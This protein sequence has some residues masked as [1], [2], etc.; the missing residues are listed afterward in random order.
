MPQHSTSLFLLILYVQR[1]WE[2]T[3]SWQILPRL[4]WW[5]EKDVSICTLALKASTWEWH[6]PHLF[7]A[8][9]LKQVTDYI[10]LSGEEEVPG[11]RRT[12]MFVNIPDDSHSKSSL[13]SRWRITG[14]SILGDKRQ[15]S[16]SFK[17][18]RAQFWRI[19][20]LQLGY[21]ARV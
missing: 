21:R 14:L 12:R 8:E 5:R 16:L 3:L 10:K 18:M 7:T 20:G 9:W 19:W 2:E 17:S 13:V 11:R 6:M 1:G 4:W 15:A